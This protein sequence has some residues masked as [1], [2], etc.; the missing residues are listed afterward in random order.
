MRDHAGLAPLL[1]YYV[2]VI[3]LGPHAKAGGD[4][5]FYTVYAQGLAELLTGGDA[6]LDL[7]TGPGYPLLLIPFL[8]FDVPVLGWKV[9][10]AAFLF[11]AVV[12][13]HA[14]L[15]LY[16]PR[17][18]AFWFAFAFGMYPPLLKESFYVLSECLAMFLM[19]AFVFHYCRLQHGGGRR[20]LHGG[21]AGLFAG[22][23]ILTKVF[24]SYVFVV[25][26]VFCAAGWLVRRRP[27]H[28]HLVGIGALALVLC[29]PYLAYTYS[30]TG[31]MFYW[32]Y[33]GGE[34]LYWMSTPYPGEWGEWHPDSFRDIDR[35][36]EHHED[37]FASLPEGRRAREPALRE[38]ALRNIRAHPRKYFMNWGA[39][40]GRLLFS[41]PF[42][43]RL[44]TPLTLLLIVPNAF[45]VVLSVLCVYPSVRR[46]RMIP[47]E[48]AI[49]L[50]FAAV[51]FG[52]SSLLA[53]YERQFRPL[54]P[55]L[56]LWVAFTV[57]RILRI[58]IRATEESAV[59]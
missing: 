55:L 11:G 41:Y 8:A 20:A 54:V 26:I 36:R 44:Q 57:T 29:S 30:V 34:A 12:Y 47:T 24:F 14:T 33:T 52:G 15:R 23:L 13:F 46:H 9:A 51:A 18:S 19:C 1:A 28:A 56:G 25:L 4:Q 39:N 48:I 42:S 40:V 7:G 49:L 38:Q 21:L 35:I 58:E 59:G 16:V 37:V 2:A 53:A 27:A 32:A 50:L 45:V 43:Y 5:Q 22:W 31:R 10:N 6:T 17:R 3:L